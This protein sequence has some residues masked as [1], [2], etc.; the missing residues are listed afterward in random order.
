MKSGVHAVRHLGDQVALGGS[1]GEVV[2]ANRTGEIT[3]RRPL[4]SVVTSISRGSAGLLTGTAEGT[5]SLWPPLPTLLRTNGVKI[6]DI[7][8]MGGKTIITTADGPRVLDSTAPGS[9][10]LTV[11]TSPG[12]GGYLPHVASDVTGSTLATQARDGKV[13][14]L[15]LAGSGYET[16][17]V[18]DET[19]RWWTWC[20]PPTAGDWP[21]DTGARSATTSISAGARVGNP[22][23]RSTP[24]RAGWPSIPMARSWPR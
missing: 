12:G 22:P 14:L 20:S 2:I 17:Q 6:H 18:I 15:R 3:E 24:G 21:S 7:R 4:R 9:P 11:P 10:E 23:E 19:P 5:L 8:R 13:V 16:E 1:Q